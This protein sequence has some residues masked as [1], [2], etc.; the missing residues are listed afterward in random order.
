MDQESDDLRHRAILGKD[1]SSM[2]T[3]HLKTGCIA[4]V[5]AKEVGTEPVR[6]SSG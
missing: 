4:A 1:V 6:L 2:I 3:R 5:T